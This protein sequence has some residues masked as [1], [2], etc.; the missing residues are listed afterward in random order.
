MESAT[1]TPVPKR[2]WRNRLGRLLALTGFGIVAWLIVSYLAVRQL[3]RRVASIREE[4]VPSIAWG[5]IE[6]LRLTSKDG[7]ELGAWYF[8]G[9]ADRP[10]VLILHGNG[11]NRSIC[12]PE[13]EYIAKTGS[14]V[15]MIS[16][17]AHGD[18]TGELNDFGYGGRHDVIAAVEWLH[19]RHPGRPV[20]IWG[21][22]MGSAAALFAAGDLGDQVSGF[23][24]ECPYQDLHIATR[25]RT[26]R[27]LPPGLEYVAYAGLSTVAPLVL[28]HTDD[29]SPLK[30]AA[31]VSKS[32]RVLV[33]AGG[34]DNRATP[35]EARA[36]ANAIGENAELVV[37]DQAGHMGVRFV[38]PE[39]F[40]R[41]VFGL[42]DQCSPPKK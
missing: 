27:V 2:T 40:Q 17:R 28:P 26:R 10:L 1:T 32:A 20:V 8:E 22:S 23:I 12:L 41:T 18:S 9:R 16:F 13:A 38:D 6:P 29:I 5:K 24:L 31:N 15:L 42:L 35:E 19:E 3:T 37:V 14:P 39:T 7:Q 25:N 36:I 33:M 30:A 21:R 34:A 4:P 11:G